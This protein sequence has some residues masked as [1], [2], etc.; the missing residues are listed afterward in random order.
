MWALVV[1][2]E[3]VLSCFVLA[4]GVSLLFETPGE[5]GSWGLLWPFWGLEEDGLDRPRLKNDFILE[6]VVFVWD[7]EED[8]EA[9]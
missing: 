4:L 5:T 9:L 2:V 7:D 1:D 3:S 8:F 6:E